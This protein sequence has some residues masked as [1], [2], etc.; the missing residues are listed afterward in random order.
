VDR[1]ALAEVRAIVRLQ[2]LERVVHCLRESGVP[3]LCVARGRAVG[4][5]VDPAAARLTL[6]EGAEEMDKA[7]VQ[8]VCA[9][10]R[11]EM[12]AELIARAA[13]TGRPGDGY[14]TV[15]PVAGVMNIR[16]GAKGLDALTSWRNQ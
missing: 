15:S 3:R 8:F 12:Y 2:M 11:C 13:H 5:G 4:A 1:S 10:E 16:T 9:G 6:E 7:V 14:V